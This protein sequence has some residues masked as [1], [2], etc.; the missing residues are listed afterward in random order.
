MLK[1]RDCKLCG[2]IFTPQT[3]NQQYCCKECKTIAK[4]K[5]DSSG[6]FDTTDSPLLECVTHYTISGV[7][8]S[9]YSFP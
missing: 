2:E 3:A 1:E 6:S 5:R 7:L 8:P 4:K 9:T